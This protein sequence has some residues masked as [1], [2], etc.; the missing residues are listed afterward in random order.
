M[1]VV[2][3]QISPMIVLGTSRSFVCATPRMDIDSVDKNHADWRRLILTSLQQRN[4]R[5]KGGFVEL[6]ASRKKLGSAVHLRYVLHVTK[7]RN[8][9][10]RLTVPADENLQA[11]LNHYKA[12]I[13]RL[14]HEKN[15]LEKVR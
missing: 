4:C 8:L 2:S 5:E 3:K 12:N 11:E 15:Q 6:I 13:N 10:T 1:C 9:C 14:E 7:G